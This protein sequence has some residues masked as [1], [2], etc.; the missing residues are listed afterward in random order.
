[1]DWSWGRIA[2]CL[3][4]LAAP[5]FRPPVV[6]PVARPK[7]AEGWTVPRKAAAVPP[8]MKDKTCSI[9]TR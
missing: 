6:L 8:H 7:E 2:G 1:M 9:T 3:K 5:L 4:A